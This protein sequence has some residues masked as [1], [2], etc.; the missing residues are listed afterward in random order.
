MSGYFDFFPLRQTAIGLTVTAVALGGLPAATQAQ[1]FFGNQGIRLAVDT[2]V[3]FE[4]LESNG[5][6][7]SV[8]GIINLE[9]GEKFP[10][11]GEV[12]DSDVPQPVNKPSSYQDDAG[13]QNQSD[14]YGSPGDTIPR[15][16]GEFRFAANTDY[17]FYLESSFGS[18]PAGTLYSTSN[19]NAGSRDYARFEGPLEDV[20]NGGL[21]LRWEDTGSLLVGDINTDYDYDDFIIRVGGHLRWDDPEDVIPIEEVRTN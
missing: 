11:Y 17:S 1:E 3:E 21:L 6:Y 8:F 13:P 12:K 14:F 7:R 15:P 18:Q 16:L 19:L 9:T 5:S 20:I 10:L 4:F 2:V